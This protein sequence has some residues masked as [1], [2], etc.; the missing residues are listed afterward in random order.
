MPARTPERRRLAAKLAGASQAGSKLDATEIR[1]E[2][3]ALCAEDYIRKLVEEAPPL[4]NEQRARLAALLA[5]GG[6]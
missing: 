4:N 1:R 5:P 6:E 2:Y 3:K